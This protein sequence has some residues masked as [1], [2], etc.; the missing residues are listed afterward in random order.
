MKVY[1]GMEEEESLTLYMDFYK[2]LQVMHQP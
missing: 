1:T 2:K